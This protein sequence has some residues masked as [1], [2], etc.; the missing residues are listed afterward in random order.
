LSIHIRRATTDDLETLHSIERECFTLEAFTK[1]Q[2]AYLLKNP[3][4]ISLIAQTKNE[5]AG[6]IV[7]LIYDHYTTRTGHVY[8]LDVAVKHRR[9]GVGVR[10]LRE[11]EQRFV[12]NGVKICYLEARRGNAAALALYRKHGYTEVDVLEN[13]YS[14]GVDGVRLIKKLC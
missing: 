3:K 7:G 11:L 9:R 13:F 2:L 5:I 1:G 8:T 6:F 12:K 10:L 14:E 4:S